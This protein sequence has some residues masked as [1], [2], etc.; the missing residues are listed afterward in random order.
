[1]PEPASALSPAEQLLAQF[2]ARIAQRDA[3]PPPPAPDRFEPPQVRA[4]IGRALAARLGDLD[5]RRL[6]SLA[7][8]CWGLM[9]G[10]RFTTA[11]LAAAA[12]LHVRTVLADM[13]WLQELGLAQMQP[14][15]RT[16]AYW[17]TR[18]GEDWLLAVVQE[19][20]LPAEPP[21]A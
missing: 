13:G 20:P 9:H 1:M 12:G 14:Q 3:P 10:P 17:L 7:A 2:A 21:T 4:R 6:R 11:Q 5:P 19:T 8:L 16:Q 18:Y 15:S